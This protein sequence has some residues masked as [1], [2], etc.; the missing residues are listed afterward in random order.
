[1]SDTRPTLVNL[2]PFVPKNAR[3]KFSFHRRNPWATI[4]AGR[5]QV[6]RLGLVRLG[7]MRNGM[8]LQLHHNCDEEKEEKEGSV[9]CLLVMEG[10]RDDLQIS[11]LIRSRV[12]DGWGKQSRHFTSNSF[13]PSL[14]RPRWKEGVEEEEETPRG[15]PR[16]QAGRR[17]VNTIF[18]PCPEK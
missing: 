11:E 9:E 17:T 10:W 5:T 15:A 4:R 7:K 2:L 12:V 16:R 1:M 14:P 13:P 6:E 18:R 3:N 8:K